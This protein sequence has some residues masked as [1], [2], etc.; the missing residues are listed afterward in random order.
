M[1]HSRLRMPGRP[2][3]QSIHRTVCRAVGASAL[4]LMTLLA[5][6]CGDDLGQEPG[7]APDPGSGG[8]DA[9]PDPDAGTEVTSLAGKLFLNEFLASPASRSDWAELVNGSAESLDI[10]GVRVG[11]VLEGGATSTVT[12]A[13][14]T[15]LAPGGF[16]RV[17]E[18]SVDPETPVCAPRFDLPEGVGEVTL[19]AADGQRIDRLVI[20]QALHGRT[21]PSM[22]LGR[23]PDATGPLMP[24]RR[25]T[26]GAANAGP[27]SDDPCL[28]PPAAG[29]FDDHTFPCVGSTDSFYWLAGSRT[30]T[31]TV[32]FTI[33]SFSDPAARHVRFLD[34]V[35]YSI[36]DEWYYFRMLNGQT[37]E[38]EDMYPPYPG[39]FSTVQDIYSW[40]L[41]TDPLPYGDGFLSFTG[42]RL[43]SARFRDMIIDIQPRI[44]GAGTLIYLPERTEPLARDEIWGFELEYLDVPSHADL[45]VFF[46]MLERNLP[47]EIFSRVRWITRSQ[48]QDALALTMEQG[49][50]RHHDRILR[51]TELSTPGEVQVYHGGLVAG[52]L[53]MVRA[54]DTGLENATSTDI[55]VVEEIPDYLPPCRA[56]I[57]AVPQ[58]PLAHI[59]LLARSRGIPNLYVANVTTDP[60]WDQL[61]RV[62]ARVALIATEPGEYR[63]VPITDEQ[64]DTWTN[65]VPD[66]DQVISPIDLSSAPFTVDLSDLTAEDMPALRPLV[67]GKAAGFLPLLD[68]GGVTTPEHPLA[69]TVRAYHE[70]IAPLRAAF[71]DWLL[72]LRE[73]RLLQYRRDR[74]LI[75]EGPDAYDERYTAGT[76]RVFKQSFLEAHPPGNWLGDLVRAGGVRAIVASTPIDPATLQE[77]EDA[78]AVRFA[79]FAPEQG[80]RF[81]SSSNVEDVEGFN[82]A[83]LY[84]STTGFIHA[85]QLTDPKDRA[86]TVEAALQQTWA[87]YWSWEA[88]DER[89]Q[90]NINHFGGDMGVVVHARFDDD[91]E[92]SNGVFTLTRFPE[93]SP[94]HAPGLFH[95]RYEMSLNVQA[96][97]LS[98][99]NPPPGQ[100]VVP[101]VVRV[102]LTAGEATPRIERLQS[103]SESQSGAGVL[104]DADILGLFEQ[105]V[106]VTDHWFAIENAGVPAAEARRTLTLDFEFR[107]MAAGWP[108]LAGG[109]PFGKR[110]IVKQARSLEP[111]VADV[112]AAVAAVPF[113]RDVLGRARRVTRR[114][115]TGEG[116][117][118]TAVEAYT[119]PLQTP[120]LGHE[121]AP[122]TATVTLDATGDLPALGWTAGQRIGMLHADFDAFDHPGMPLAAP[123]SLTADVTAG[124]RVAVGLER[125]V[126]TPNQRWEITRG[127]TTA[128]GAAFACTEET[129]HSTP[130]NYL[131]DLLAAAE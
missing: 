17:S 85:D 117:T 62:R 56:L 34:S 53:R 2:I 32:K 116:L 67:G 30:D 122:F 5:S 10:S 73:F 106:A 26:P 82:G 94:A 123:W 49:Q 115:C 107:Q 113:P 98:V 96:G 77:I 35:F 20:D 109:A 66:N 4:S 36:H 38:G 55:L 72:A 75:L 99:T 50:L 31:S 125:L 111:S 84:E 54:G 89:L 90:A 118:L 45:M 63:F 70:H 60:E 7:Q 21:R 100:C 11:G 13:A 29:E 64:Y 48:A 24:Q 6:G 78:I 71:L 52:R 131:L 57:T 33:P 104:S 8:R 127:A 81:R 23:Y 58:T 37:V 80:L 121:L 46:D 108:A 68:T 130:D 114:V 59:N 44:I 103:S 97:S 92:V 40:A 112:P 91:L 18:A 61:G 76:G 27:A 129:L 79:D 22:S 124:S 43:I 93:K 87:S 1:L 16:L 65:L 101:E 25:P 39:S 95:D 69:V 128:G 88:Y 19:E 15:R 105:A 42:E 9:G 110:M 47:P 74:Y 51:Y 3:V 126:W 12:V 28:K 14:G 120:D 41:V 83:G 102:R 119:D 86:R